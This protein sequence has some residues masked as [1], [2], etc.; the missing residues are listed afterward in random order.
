MDV[1]NNDIVY[2]LLIWLIGMPFKMAFAVL[3]LF[4]TGEQTYSVHCTQNVYK[5]LV[6]FNIK[7]CTF[8]K[9]SV[10]V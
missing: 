7:V 6:Q 4:G 3:Q 5:Y 8:V 9:G 2:L 1:V 10:V